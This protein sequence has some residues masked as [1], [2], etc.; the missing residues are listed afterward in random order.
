[1]TKPFAFDELTACACAAARPS[2]ARSTRLAASGIELHV[3]TNLREA[4]WRR[5]C[6]LE[7]GVRAARVFP[8]SSGERALATL[9]SVVWA[10]SHDP[11]TNVVEVYVSHLRRKLVR[12]GSPAPI[13]TV[14][15][16]GCRLAR[17]RA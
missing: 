12:P 1:M 16:A 8:A 7:E 9:H 13:V 5:G 3:L 17:P 15:S 2:K 6:N 10:Y 11:G 4:R 14:R